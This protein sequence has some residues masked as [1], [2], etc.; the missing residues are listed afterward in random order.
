M[1][2][3]DILYKRLGNTLTDLPHIVLLNLASL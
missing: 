3:C 1:A 2:L